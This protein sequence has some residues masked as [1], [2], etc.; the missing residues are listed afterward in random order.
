MIKDNLNQQNN[1]DKRFSQQENLN[2]ADD[3]ILTH[4]NQNDR[5]QFKSE[6]KFKGQQRT[7]P[8]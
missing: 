1:K 2:L 8:T 4:L 7:P 6:G 5:F 3:T